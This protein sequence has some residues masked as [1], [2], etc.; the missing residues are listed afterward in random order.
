MNSARAKKTISNAISV[1]FGFITP[2]CFV[3]ELSAQPIFSQNDIHVVDK[4]LN[5]AIESSDE[6]IIASGILISELHELEL[7]SDDF[8]AKAQKIDISNP[9]LILSLIT[10]CDEGLPQ[11]AC[12]IPALLEKLKQIDT[13]NSV[14]Y[15]LSALY[16]DGVGDSSGALSELEASSNSTSFDDYFLY[17]A[18]FLSEILRGIRYSEDN[19]YEHAFYYSG[20]DL[21][22]MYQGVLVLCEKHVE[23]DESWKSACIDMGKIMEDYGRTFIAVRT[24]LGVQRSMYSFDTADQPLLEAVQRRR[25]FTHRWRVLRGEKLDQLLSISGDQYYL[26]QFER[27]EIYAI[28][29]AF[30]RLQGAPDPDSFLNRQER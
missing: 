16:L 1:L 6:R 8:L 2:F 17:R 28:N 21:I 18:E 13:N 14:P 26:D 30:Q 19:I 15:L 24:G 7:S 5:Q 22:Y 12:N 25:A 20:A 9:S 4:W 23:T 10:N 29:Q 11:S 3:S 27:D